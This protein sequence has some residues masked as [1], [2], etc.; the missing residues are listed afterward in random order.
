[1]KRLLFALATLVIVACGN[2]VENQTVLPEHKLL[3]I[4]E[5]IVSSNG[6]ISPTQNLVYNIEIDYPM[7][8]DS[9]ELIQDYFIE[10]GETDFKGV[11]KILVRAYLKGTTITEMPYACLNLISGRKRII[12]NKGA[13]TVHELN[14]TTLSKPEQTNADSFVGTYHCNRTHDTYVFKSNNTGYFT[15][16]GGNSPSEFTWKRSGKNVTIVYEVWGEQKLQFDQ[17]AQTLTEKSK[18]FGTLVFDKQ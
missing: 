2:N 11:N 1:M 15:I 17:K 5:P 10:K 14:K 12:I 6:Y 7:P 8:E 9:L 4:A 18:S 3:N 16:K 13:V